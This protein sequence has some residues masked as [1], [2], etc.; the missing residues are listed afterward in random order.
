MKIALLLVSLFLPI[1]AL[2][3]L[4][5]IAHIHAPVDRISRD[6][7][8]NIYM[9]RLRRFP[10]GESVQPVDGPAKA[11]FYRLLVN[12]EL[13]DINAYWARLVFSG[14][15]SPPRSFEQNQ[16][17]LDYVSANPDAIGYVERTE[18]NAKVK[19]ILDM[20]H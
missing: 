9:G 5:L 20:E 17:V 3:D 19:V 11:Q 7:A 8:I 15:T 1:S 12:K 6:E 14:R 2:A 4:V 13:A 10:S 16:A 18:L